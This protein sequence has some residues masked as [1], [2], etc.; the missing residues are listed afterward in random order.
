MTKPLLPSLEEG[1]ST[2]QIATETP[3]RESRRLILRH[4]RIDLVGPGVDAA[5]QVLEPVEAR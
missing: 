3:V 4:A 5:G 1:A 2:L